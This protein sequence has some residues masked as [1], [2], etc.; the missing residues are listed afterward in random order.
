MTYINK[1]LIRKEVK[2]YLD[3]P[4]YKVYSLFFIY[5]LCRGY[6]IL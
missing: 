5:D 1:E 2:D 6:F 4:R 3:K